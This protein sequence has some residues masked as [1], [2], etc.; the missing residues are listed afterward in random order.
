MET[1][2]YINFDGLLNTGVSDFLMK[3]DELTACKNVWV[4][5]IG[6][7]EK[8]PGYELADADS[9]VY[10]GKDVNYLH[11]YYR[12]STKIDYLLGFSDTST[13]YGVRQRTTGDWGAVTGGSWS[14]RAGAQVSVAN[15]L[16]KAFIVGIDGTTFLAP[17]TI[18]GTVA[19]DDGAVD[20]DIA[21]MPKGKYI[22]R[23]RN[24]LYVLHAYESAT[25]YPSRVY[26]CDE[27]TAGATGWTNV[28]SAFI[29]FGHD[30]GDEITGG[31]EVIDRLIVFKR[32]SMWKYDETE[33]KRVANVGCDSYRSI[34][35]INEVVYWF[36]RKG[37]YRWGGKIP[38]LISAKIQKFIDGIAETNLG[39]VVASIYNEN[40]YRAFIGT[41]TVDGITYTNCWVCFNVLRER[42]YIR[43]TVDPGK[44][45][46]QYIE[47]GSGKRR[48]YWGNANGDVHKFAQKVDNIY[49]DNGSEIDSFFIT[50]ALDHGAPEQRK[51][52]NH[53]TFFTKYAQGMKV[54]VDTDRKNEFNVSQIQIINKNVDTKDFQAE[55][56]RYT[57]K[58]HEKGNDKSWEFEGFVVEVE[59]KGQDE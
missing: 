20:T 48:M 52:A 49:N 57:Y 40:E 5:Q 33:V 6:K 4:Y 53:M 54:S 43:C 42:W 46:C 39:N 45:A 19:E 22:V 15:F 41:V 11:H 8:V 16:D 12:P 47:S 56:N 51:Y 9:K 21:D 35:S 59:L 28:A 2:R 44:S 36:N 25:L 55:G 58:F 24:L 13:N 29:E 30:D 17:T 31:A 3:E 32:Y 38:Q 50:K 14:G 1:V 37:F 34:A 7:L 26:Y 10:T 23:F 18:T 27:V